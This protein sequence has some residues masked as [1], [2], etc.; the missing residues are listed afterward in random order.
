MSYLFDIY[1]ITD[2]KIIDRTKDIIDK[3]ER[4]SAVQPVVDC[5]VNELS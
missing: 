1:H 5:L 2:K 4:I 3:A